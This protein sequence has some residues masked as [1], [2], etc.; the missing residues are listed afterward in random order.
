MKLI[1]KAVGIIG[2]ILVFLAFVVGV[3]VQGEGPNP[4]NDPQ[5]WVSWALADAI[6]AF[7]LLTGAALGGISAVAALIQILGKKPLSKVESRVAHDRIRDKVEDDGALTRQA[8][9]EMENRIVARLGGDQ[10]GGAPADARTQRAT[11]DAVREIVETGDAAERAAAELLAEG[12]LDEGFA[13]LRDDAQAD[14]RKAADKWRR[15]GALAYAVDAAVAA[16]AYGRAAERDPADVWTHLYLGRLHRTLGDLAAARRAVETALAT[17]SDPRDRSCA[18]DE[19]GNVAVAEGDLPGARKAYEDALAI[20]KDLSARDPK[21]TEWLRDLSVSYNKLGDVAVAEGDLPG[22]R[23]AYEDGLVIRKDLSA[24]DP[25]NTT[26]LRDLS[27]S[28]NKLGDVAVAEG[29]LPGARKAFEDSLVIHKDLS[30]RDP[31]NTEWRRDLSVSYD[32]L[33][34]VAVAEGDLPGARKAYED[35]LVIRIDLSARDPGN[36]IW[37]RDLWN[38][39]WRLAQDPEAS[40]SWGEVRDAISAEKARGTLLPDDERF[41]HEATRLAD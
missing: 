40:V 34:D 30:A 26:W 16:E 28:Y 25:K 32:R 18:L 33:G 8:M 13:R 20:A 39:L 17:A 36:A 21:N 27:I 37:R 15:L 29:D 19:L 9:T 22:A 1:T 5:A 31:K 41:L 11:I 3:L 7:L 24:R 12:R 38:S 23:K 6:S 14:D 10:P 35:A 2:L 4:I